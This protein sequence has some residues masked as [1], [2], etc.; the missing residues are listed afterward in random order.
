M[1]LLSVGVP[2][3]CIFSFR[4]PVACFFFLD[5]QLAGCA[6]VGVV[7][8]EVH[9]FVEYTASR[10]QQWRI[11]QVAHPKK[12][13][14][15]HED[16]TKNA[17]ARNTNRKKTHKNILRSSARSKRRRWNMNP[18]TS[19]AEPAT[20]NRCMRNLIATTN[21]KLFWLGFF[22]EHGD[23]APAKKTEFLQMAPFLG[24]QRPRRDGA[25]S[26]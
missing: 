2:C 22:L 10:I 11:Q 14:R 4:L 7:S 23:H 8:R 19:R 18:I 24:E 17:K 20:E 5:V 15:P 16:E 1:R 26:G 12:R 6:I 21:T 25:P 9:R 13:S 3:F